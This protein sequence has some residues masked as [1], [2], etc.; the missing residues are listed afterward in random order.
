MYIHDAFHGLFATD[1]VEWGLADQHL[2]RKDSY[3]PDIDEVVVGFTLQDL[4]A[5]VVESAAI[6]CSSLFA[7]CRPPEVTQLANALNY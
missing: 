2:V 4:W 1:V 3:C 6:G 7:V 5:D